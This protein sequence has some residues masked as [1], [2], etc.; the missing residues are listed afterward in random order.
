M[1]YLLAEW[2][3]SES[4]NKKGYLQQVQGPI[5]LLV[6]GD[7]HLM[8]GQGVRP[9]VDQGEGLSTHLLTFKYTVSIICL[10]MNI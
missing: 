3:N 5:D 4:K 8:G 7:P 2:I 9:H 6:L 10:R 1:P